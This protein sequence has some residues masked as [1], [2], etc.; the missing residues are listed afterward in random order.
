M[1]LVFL[2]V[3]MLVGALAVAFYARPRLHALR[4]QVERERTSAEER[5]ALVQQLNASW[6]QRF[7][8]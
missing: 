8:R 7:Q 4:D 2:I 1:A 3:G 5:V 6:E